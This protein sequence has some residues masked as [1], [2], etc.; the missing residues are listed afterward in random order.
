M[1][2]SKKSIEIC[3]PGAVKSGRI[4][5]SLVTDGAKGNLMV[6][7]SCNKWS[8][9]AHQ[10]PY[11]ILQ[12]EH[13]IFS[14]PEPLSAFLDPVPC[15]VS[16]ETTGWDAP[17]LLDPAF[18]CWISRQPDKDWICWGCWGIRCAKVWMIQSSSDGFCMVFSKNDQGKSFLRG[19]ATRAIVPTH[20][21]LQ[22]SLVDLG[23]WLLW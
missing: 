5:F 23:S 13:F 10:F 1:F 9:V 6:T 21:T 8:P 17:A 7:I 14:A 18:P 20:F 11:L 12:A 4:S 2:R 22:G 15:V 16:R 3:T 19:P